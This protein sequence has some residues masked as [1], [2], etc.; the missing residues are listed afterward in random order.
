MSIDIQAVVWLALLIIL[1][2]IEAAT[3]GLTTI[4]FAGGALVAF[5]LSVFGANL[6]IQVILFCIVSLVLLL[7]TRPLAMRWMKNGRTRTNAESL[8]GE[9]GIVTEAIDNLASTGQVQVH[10]QI[11]TARADEDALKIGKDQKVRIEKISGV[12]LI[13]KEENK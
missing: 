1:L 5:L 13:V 2:I 8:I 3:Q 12:K 7:F 10:G 11:W 9:T 4:W 6:F